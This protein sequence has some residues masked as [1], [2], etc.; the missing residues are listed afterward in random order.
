MSWYFLGGFL[1]ILDRPVRPLAEPCRCSTHVR[2]VRRALK[3]D[4]E[5]HLHAVF[6][7]LG[8]KSPEVLASYQV[9]GE[10]TCDRPPPLRSPMG[11]RHRLAAPAVNYSCPCEGC[12]RWDGWAENKRYRN[13]SRQCTAATLRNPKMFRAGPP[14]SNR[15]EEILRTRSRSEPSRDRR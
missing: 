10:W 11:F 14:E 4:V 12:A 13:P 5:S 15:N 3:S 7:R 9:P 6:R 1:G 2:M 8:E